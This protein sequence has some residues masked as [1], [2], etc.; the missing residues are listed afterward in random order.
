MAMC[1]TKRRAFLKSS[2]MLVAGAGTMGK[3][4][5]HRH[6]VGGMIHSATVNNVMSLTANALLAALDAE[7]LTKVQ[8]DINA[9]ERRNWHYVPF[10]RK[11]LPLRQM[12]PYQ[13]H[14][15]S[16][17]LAAGLIKAALSKQSP[18]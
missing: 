3:A 7:Q 15:A 1:D 14:L 18:S 9:D 11:G 10:E 16:A 2:A 13:R 5:A 12:S 17:L 8:I 6:E 4:P